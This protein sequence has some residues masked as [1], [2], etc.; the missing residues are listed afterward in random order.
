MAWIVKMPKL[1]QTME[2]GLVTG[3]LK[4]IGDPV[5]IGEPLVAIEAEKFTGE[6]EARED[7]V[8][9][10]IL[11]P[12]GEE[13]APGTPIGVVAAPDEDTPS[14]SDTGTAS[15][16]T[17]PADTPKDVAAATGPAAKS[18]R[19]KASPAAKKLAREKQVDLSQVTGTGPEQ[20]VTVSDVEDFL[21]AGN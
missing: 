6:V 13:V 21:A 16:I 2:T 15:Q 1:G 17:A 5:R 3:W 8:L 4:G 20:S 19:V 7:G 9:R 14:L 10:E 11:V 12:A 18:G